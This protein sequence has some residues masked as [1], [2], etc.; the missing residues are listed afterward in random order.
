MALEPAGA[1]EHSTI[2]LHKS[3]WAPRQ[4]GV[5]PDMG[6]I[7][8]M[9]IRVALCL[10]LLGAPAALAGYGL[11]T[12]QEREAWR[13]DAELACLAEGRVTRSASIRA[14]EEIVGAG[15]CGVDHPFKIVALDDGAVTLDRSARL[16]CPM[17]AALDTW[18]RAVVEPAAKARFGVAVAEL[19]NARS[20]QC[21]PVEAGAEKLSE[22]AFG[23]AVDIAGFTL[24][25]GRVIS[26]ADDWDGGAPQQ[27]A[28]LRDV[29][30]GACGLFRTVLGPGADGRHEDHLHLDLARLDA[31]GSRVY[32]AP[33]PIGPGRPSGGELLMSSATTDI[34]DIRTGSI[35][36]RSDVGDAPLGYRSDD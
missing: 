8:L 30:A 23:N 35:A 12:H 17:T 26:V 29:H 28:F 33:K 25:D 13:G 11:M 3:R 27:R 6:L 1:T 9:K 32:C 14:T 19:R 24:V 10:A 16:G 21:R 5:N 31:D 7:R 18:V 36:P 15:L 20:Y 4:A 2:A 34:D 22:H